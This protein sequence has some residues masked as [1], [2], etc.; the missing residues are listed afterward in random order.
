M[1]KE[2]Q[3]PILIPSFLIIARF[4]FDTEDGSR[5]FSRNV[6]LHLSDYTAVHPGKWRCPQTPLRE[7]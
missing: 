6:A 3:C 7:P 5:T 4:H 1:G 2:E